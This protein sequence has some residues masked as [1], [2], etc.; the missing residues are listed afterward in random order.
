M[1]NIKS[2]MVVGVFNMFQG[3]GL[4]MRK[5]PGEI[6]CVSKTINCIECLLVSAM[7]W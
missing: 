4:D 6:P 1:T 3:S 7:V 5:A 2:R